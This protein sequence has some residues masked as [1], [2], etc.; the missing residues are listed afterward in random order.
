MPSKKWT[1]I[2]LKTSE[3]PAGTLR[4]YK[5]PETVLVVNNNPDD[6]DLLPI[7]IKL[8]SPKNLSE[9]NGWGDPA[10]NQFFRR[11]ADIYPDTARSL[12]SLQKRFATVEECTKHLKSNPEKYSEEI[13]YIQ[14][15]WEWRM[16]GYWFMNCGRPTFIS[17]PHWLYLNHWFAGAHRPHYRSR[18][19]KFFHFYDFVK[20]DPKCCGFNYPKFRREGA[21]SKT[22]CILY[23][24]VS[25]K[26]SAHGGIQSKDDQSAQRVFQKEVVRCW[27]KLPFWFKPIQDGYSDPKGS[28]NFFAPSKN[29]TSGT[30]SNFEDSLESWIDYGA[31]TE[32]YYDGDKLVFHYGDETGKASRVNVYERHTIVRPSVTE[33]NQYIGT[34]VNTSTVGEME[35][36]GGKNFKKLCKHSNFH[37]RDENGETITGLYNLFIPSY[38]GFS[39]KDPDTGKPFINKFGDS[40]EEATK[41]YLLRKRDAKLKAGDIEGYI[42]EVRMFPLTFA[43]CFTK[44]SKVS[45]FN[46]QIITDRLQEF[47]FGNEYIVTGNFEWVNGQD[48]QV[49]WVPSK[50]GRWKTSYV[51]PHAS[52]NRSV[53]ENGVMVPGNRHRFIAGGDPFKVDSPDGD[54]KSDGAGCV[55]WKFDPSVDHPSADRSTWKSERFV[56]TYSNRPKTKEEYGEDMIKM[57]VY[58]G[59]EM[60]PEVNVPFLWEHFKKRGYIGYLYYSIDLK[61]G[62]F[63]KTPGSSTNEKVKD[64]IFSEWMSHIEINGSRELHDELLEQCGEIEDDMGPFDLFVAGGYALMGA[65]RQE[66]APSQ[67]KSIKS[68]HR[69]FTYS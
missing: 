13:A 62:R 56:C 40:D 63:N 67:I 35:G 64:A 53:M 25:T 4:G 28:L 33:G 51:I 21:T 1:K 36:G 8:P 57:C 7:E 59:C 38:D 9:L 69:K 46:M 17:G 54:K 26:R 50:T 48:S 12:R 37:D 31:S 34:I 60:Y 2:Y 47:Q 18:D 29:T 39:G 16:N 24:E 66:Q 58:Y 41:R 10:P 6:K 49:M 44:S 11:H 14:R 30:A 23:H 65:R 55:F 43:E 52:A 27:K 19:R 68:F 45:N 42:E 20:K 15:E 3:L 32:E 5:D 22:S 61:T